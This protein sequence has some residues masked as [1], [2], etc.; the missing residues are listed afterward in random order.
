MFVVIMKDQLRCFFDKPLLGCSTGG[1]PSKHH[2]IT[3]GRVPPCL[4][5]REWHHPLPFAHPTRINMATEM[6]ADFPSSCQKSITEIFLAAKPSSKCKKPTQIV[7]FLS[8]LG[9]DSKEDLCSR[10]GGIPERPPPPKGGLGSP[11]HISRW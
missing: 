3:F 1:K 2:I 8:L 9:L 7:C 4:L 5:I 11:T 10:G 6:S